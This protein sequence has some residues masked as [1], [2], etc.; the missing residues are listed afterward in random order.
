MKTFGV[1]MAGGG[2][3]RF[4]PLSR[5]DTPKQLLNL[6]GKD[7]MI[8]EAIDR[9]ALICDYKDI[10]IVTNRTQERQLLSLLNGRVD[11][12]RILAEPAARNTAACIGF[13]AIHILKKYGDGIMVITPS[14]AYIKDTENFAEVVKRAVKTAEETDKLVTIGIKPNFPSTGYGYIQC[15]KTDR[16]VKNVLR[17][18]EKPNEETAKK[19]LKSGDF[20]WNSGMFV[21]R[22]S[23]I[24]DMIQTYLPEIYSCIER[25]AE[26]FGTEKEL[27]TINS[28]YPTIPSI[29]VDYGI[30][31]QSKDIVVVPGDFGWNDVGSWDMFHVLHKEDAEGNIQVG[32]TLALGTTRTIIYSSSKLV[33]ALGVDNLVIVETP[34]AILV[35]N[36]DKAQDIKQIVEELKCNGKEDVL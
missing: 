35:C 5:K 2:G 33:T 3:T 14:D 6:S 24:L 29:S 23:T 8:N 13:A 27:E 26:S 15:E 25:I 22:V 17:F 16:A 20:L 11:S 18:V 19:Y 36:K 34:D 10:F 28:I 7:I 1:I 4:W 31:E 21:W 9:L 30:M 12:E 32:E